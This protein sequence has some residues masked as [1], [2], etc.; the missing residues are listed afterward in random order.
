M[1]MKKIK[2][3]IIEDEIQSSISLKVDIDRYCPEVNIIGEAA[4]VKN[5][6]MAINTL[7]PDLVF[8]DINLGD[9]TGFNILENVTFKDFKVIFITA[10][11][12]YAIKGFQVSAI[13]FLLKPIDP[14]D[15][16]N[17]V[18]KFNHVFKSEQFVQQLSI[19]QQ[20]LNTLKSSEYE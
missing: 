4:N 3:I 1:N 11:N 5:G 14:A 2:A 18:N 9:G 20:S 6:V 17:A 10:H 12:E 15:L 8:L 7:M 19:L 16:I 13:D